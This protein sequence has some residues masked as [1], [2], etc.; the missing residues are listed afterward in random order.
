MRFEALEPLTGRGPALGDRRI[1]RADRIQRVRAPSHWTSAR[2][3]AWLDW[4]EALPDDL[5]AGS[6]IT[7][8]GDDGAGGEVLGGGP[9]RHAR[10][11]AAWGLKL[12]HFD[13][14]GARAFARDLVDVF[15]AGWAAPGSALAFGARLHPLVEDPAR[16]PATAVMR[17]DSAAAWIPAANDVLA[18]RLAAVVEAVRRCQ[19]DA[20]ACADPA[21]NQV[22]ARA[23]R[24]ARDAG[25]AGATDAAIADR[26][27]LARAGQ[28]APGAP[29]AAILAADRGTVANPGPEARRAAASAWA[30][31]DL[32]LV[33]DD[34]DALALDRAAA[35]PRALIDLASIPDDA[36]LEAVA[37]LLAVAL[38]IEASVGFSALAREAFIRR[39]HRPA[40]LALAGLGD[41][42][43]AE[44]LAYG[45][46]AARARAGE[47]TALVGGAALAM[48]ADLAAR[49]G[50]YP[51]FAAERDARLAD[52][53]RRRD[54][55]L[56]LPAG[57]TADR[58]RAA[59]E[60]A[61]ATAA[62]HGL[63]N[64]QVTGPAA[65]PEMALRLG[66]QTLDHAPWAGPVALAETADGVM[67]PVLA[68]A[69]LRGLAALGADADAARA[70]VLGRR[71]LRD[72]PALDPTALA[73]RGFTDHEI[74]A[75]EEAL[76]DAPSLRAAFAPAVVG[77]GFLRDVLGAPAEAAADPDFDT[78]ALAGFGPEAIAR[79]EAWALGTGSLTDA[80]FLD[81][82]AR[83]VFAAA[84]GTPIDDRIAMAVATDAFAC[85]P[86]PVTLGLAFEDSPARA[87]DLQA[88]AAAAGVRALSIHRAPPPATF[89]LRLPDPP[90]P[91]VRAAPPPRDRIVE[92]IVEVDRSRQRLPD[93]R[94]GYIQK[95]TIGG[96]KVYL[97]TGE[98]DDGEL[99]EIFIDMH[100]EGAAF[101]SLMNNFAIAISIGLQYGVPLDEF[102]EA[103]VF[104]RFEPS[105]AVTGNDSIRSAT[106]I[107]DYVFRELGV[108]YLD[109]RDLANLDPG[110]L[111][112]DGIGGGAPEPQ[113]AARFMSKGFARGAAPD[114]LV[115][116]PVAARGGAGAAAGPL[117]DV[118]PACGDLAMVRKGQSLICQTCGARQSGAGDPGAVRS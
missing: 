10:R 44:A 16:S 116:L 70:H 18:A 89:S 1:E 41:R 65:D 2:V 59:W 56:A 45:G 57:P 35:G 114:N 17:L 75:V 85:A 29:A 111:N 80:P 58:A 86:L 33:F 54:A 64:A 113:P 25:H 98:Y 28:T 68:E 103:F 97:H 19:G 37:A 66:R 34:I 102:V 9:G 6:P 22:L 112:P 48:S 105:G 5:P 32:T 74:A 67:V 4:A 53:A 83:S 8:A 101:R 40:S 14:D 20:D 38:D 87:A 76:R 82:A 71:S 31:A 26:V 81:D 30:G 115:F 42:L 117:A 91:E 73:A 15:L 52:L 60:H 84:P 79:A 118:C 104:T 96:H 43:V 36:T 62:Q 46:A 49:L 50:P 77:V 27:A 88:R 99:G 63:R 21:Q 13:L 24:A 95:A 51:A 93:R 94:K 78:L 7:L 92:R 108:S 109:R 23:A 61:F 90:A 11:L 110:E 106:S 100:K 107:L 72:A 3:E 12:G 47:L 55:A 39:D 69:A